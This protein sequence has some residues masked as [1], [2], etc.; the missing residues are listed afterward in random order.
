[1]I[2]GDWD[3]HELV[4]RVMDIVQEICENASVSGIWQVAVVRTRLNG[5]LEEK[6]T[7]MEVHLVTCQL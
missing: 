5:A 1:M 2:G 4:R 6:E 3:K 7:R